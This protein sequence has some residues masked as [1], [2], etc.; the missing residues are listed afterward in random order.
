M[1]GVPA[2]RVRPFLPVHSPNAAHA[3]SLASL[4]ISHRHGLGFGAVLLLSAAIAATGWLR[5]AAADQAAAAALDLAHRA[6]ATSRW[7]AMTELNINRALAIVKAGGSADADKF[8]SPQM[9]ATSAEIS[10]LQK[11]LVANVDTA[12][13]RRLMSEI[14]AKRSAYLDL[15]KKVLALQ[16]AQD[17]SAPA[18]VDG[19][20]VPASVSYLGSLGELK[21][22][23][24]SL[25]QERARETEREI[26][27][28]KCLLAVLAS[29]CL[30]VGAA[31]AWVISRS[32]TRPLRHAA[33]MT[34]AVAGGD[35]ST[36]V[37]ADGADE[38]SDVLRGLVA[39]QASLRDVV[40]RVRESAESVSTASGEIASGNADLSV[41]TERAAASLQET[42]ASMHE[43]T[44]TVRQSADSAN[45][46]NQLA[47]SAAD[48]AAQGG[49]LV[50]KV[51]TTMRDISDSSRRI[52]EIISVIDGIAFQTNILALNAAVEAAR[53]GEQGRGFAVVAGEVRSLAQRSATAAKEI[54]ALIE[55]SVQRVDSGSRLVG[56]AG[57][58]MHR[59]VSSVRE[60]SQVVD[61]IVAVASEQSR[62]IGEVNIAV[63]TLDTMTQQNAARVEESAAAAE[64]LRAQAQ[65]LT[66]AVGAFKLD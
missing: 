39:M 25:A 4:K 3:M 9:K 14:E 58:T 32:V 6:Q 65:S 64:S 13:A 60:V 54:K 43:I 31:L 19:Q 57:E 27:L 33:E 49:E 59:I 7:M 37:Q 5:L 22:L 16:K 47:G 12:E 44:G 8:F 15:R 36:R 40:S 66:V 29:I 10:T 23:Q 48:I 17:P 55:T 30:G 61:A 20:L 63:A 56:H 46:A 1:P 41:R 21:K 50:D 38:V 42:A 62:G 52:S 45:T 11:E 24:Q 26:T 51:V 53:A 2:W 18:L 35:L 34:A 28:S